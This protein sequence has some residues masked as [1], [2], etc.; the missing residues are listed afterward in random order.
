[1]RSNVRTGEATARGGVVRSGLQRVREDGQ[2]R[3]RD[4]LPPDAPAKAAKTGNFFLPPLAPGFPKT[5][6]SAGEV[7]RADPK[8]GNCDAFRQRAFLSQPAVV[9]RDVQRLLQCGSFGLAVW[10]PLEGA[11]WTFTRFSTRLLTCSV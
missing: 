2:N 3:R 8:A 1:M 10:G 6:G 7:G 11:R 5:A 4:A 9:H